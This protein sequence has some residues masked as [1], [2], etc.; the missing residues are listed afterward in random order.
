[1]EASGQVKPTQRS[2]FF[3]TTESEDKNN[4]EVSDGELA[5]AISQNKDSESEPMSPSFYERA[6]A[7]YAAAF[8]PS[9]QVSYLRSTTLKLVMHEM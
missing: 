5:D 7:A 1:M 2:M 3:T 4:G 9:P 8:P 6:N